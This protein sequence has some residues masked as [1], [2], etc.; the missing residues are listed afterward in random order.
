MAT[1]RYGCAIAIGFLV[2]AVVVIFYPLFNPTDISKQDP[3][4]VFEG[5]V[6]SPPP[7]SLKAVE[8]NGSIAFAGGGVRIRFECAGNDFDKVLTRGR[9]RP[10]H[11]KDPKWIKEAEPFEN[12][13]DILRYVRDNK[14]MTET[15]LFVTK[16]RQKA[17]FYETHF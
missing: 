2:V 17:Y 3:L 13:S 15:A 1:K 8:A 11:D 16:D 4:R 9:F 5:F 10:M 6:C 7:A 12:T 14:V